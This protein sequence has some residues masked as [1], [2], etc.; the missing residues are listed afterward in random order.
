M[1]ESLGCPRPGVAEIT[2]FSFVNCVTLPVSVETEQEL[3]GRAHP[4]L[5]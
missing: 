1:S 5:K 4:S 2:A 3:A